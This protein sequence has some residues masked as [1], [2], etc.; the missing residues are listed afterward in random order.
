MLSAAGH[1]QTCAVRGVP[2]K[3]SRP[4]PVRSRKRVRASCSRKK[5]IRAAGF[6]W[7]RNAAT[8]SPWATSGCRQ[9]DQTVMRAPVDSLATPLG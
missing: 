9:R 7:P 4:S 8:R 6:G 1:G 2:K 3:I 5:S